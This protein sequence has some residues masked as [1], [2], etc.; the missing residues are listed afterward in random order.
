MPPS[1]T[2]NGIYIRSRILLF[3]NK[4]R[5]NI[6]YSCLIVSVRFAITSVIKPQSKIVLHLPVV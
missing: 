5:I 6:I 4:R 2:L 1:I 3:K